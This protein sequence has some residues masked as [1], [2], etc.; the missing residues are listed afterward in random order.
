VE[1]QGDAGAFVVKG[2]IVGSRTAYK[3]F[4]VDIRYL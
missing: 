2:R 3:I 1:D 4:I